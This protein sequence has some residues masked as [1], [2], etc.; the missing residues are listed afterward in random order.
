[1][2]THWLILFAGILLG[3]VPPRLL[4]NCDCRYLAFEDLWTKVLR[5]PA[6]EGRRRRWWK[7]PLVWIDPCRG[8]VVAWLLRSAFTPLREGTAFERLLPV[9]L[10]CVLLVIVVWLQTCGRRDERESLSPTGFMAGVILQMLPPTVAVATLVM[11]AASA[12]A[13]QS[14]TAG[15]LAAALTAAGVGFAF[16]GK[17]FTLA[18]AT[19]L[20]GLPVVINFLRGTRLVM[21]VRY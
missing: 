1:M 10:S 17:S 13:M 19:L 11:G 21:P 7:M 14:F 5:R 3:L 12:V 15:Y 2:T 18:S 8:F 16:M 9:I 20:I 6:E 4:I